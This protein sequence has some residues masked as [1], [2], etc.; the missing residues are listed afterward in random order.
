[1]ATQ[2]LRIERAGAATSAPIPKFASIAAH[3]FANFGINGALA[4]Y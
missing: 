2:G 4:T 3:P 1:M